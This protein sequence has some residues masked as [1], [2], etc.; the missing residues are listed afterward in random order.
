LGYEYINARGQKYFLHTKI[1]TNENRLYF[2]SKKPEDSIDMPEGYEVVE[3][4]KTG[5][6]LLKKKA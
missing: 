6:P 4:K 3:N 2:F 1:G 5:L